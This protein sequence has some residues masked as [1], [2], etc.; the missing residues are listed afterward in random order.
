MA[1]PTTRIAFPEIDIEIDLSL[2]AGVEPS[3]SRA[4]VAMSGGV[5]SSVAAALLLEAGFDVVGVTF[6][7][8]NRKDSDE[9]FPEAGCCTALDAADARRVASQLGIDYYVIDASE[10]FETAVVQ[11]FV[12]GYLDGATPN[13]CIECN[14]SIKFDLL[15]ERA[16]LL[17]CQVVAT[18]HHAR[19]IHPTKSGGGG[20]FPRLLRGKDRRKDQSYVLYPVKPWHL[21]RTVFPIGELTKEQ[22]RRIARQL[23]LRTAEKD[24]SQGICFVGRRSIDDF[25]RELGAASKPLRIRLED[26]TL[27]GESEKSFLTIGQ[28]RG[29]KGSVGR[30]LYVK[31][32]DRRRGEAVLGTRTSLYVAQLELGRFNWIA[33]DLP[34]EK[35]RTEVCIRY[36]AEP[37]P[38]TLELIGDDPL[39]PGTY[40]AL[41]HFD[42][43]VWAPAPGQAAVC[44]RG[45][46]VL[47]GGT[48]RATQLSSPATAENSALAAS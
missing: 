42:G 28:R 8:W 1:G 41:V 23:E 27:L 38:A 46:Q 45:E 26:G 29:A 30:R 6:K 5:D 18:G 37:E 3:R 25:M 20:V 31:T 9:S 7:L 2:P 36:G 44:Y 24:E 12:D 33:G 47:G 11:P 32:I 16:D 21:S 15:L 34:R 35:L 22:V 48:I 39:Y 17:D 10:S 19:V 13:P 4:L 14:R 43:E 40:R